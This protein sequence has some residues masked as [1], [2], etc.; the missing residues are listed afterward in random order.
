MMGGFFE[1]R[2]W[3]SCYIREYVQVS[4]DQVK[5]KVEGDSC[6]VG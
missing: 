4:R 5:D 1:W 2:A 6:D 3:S